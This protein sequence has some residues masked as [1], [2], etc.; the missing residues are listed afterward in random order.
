M[1]STANADSS[2]DGPLKTPRAQSRFPVQPRYGHSTSGSESASDLRSPI[3]AKT[4]LPTRSHTRVP[5]SQYNASQ[6]AAPR[7]PGLASLALGNERSRSNSESIIQSTQNNR[8]K[9]NG[10][11]GKKHS[12]LGVLDE[13]RSNRNSHHL[14]GQS[15]G[16]ALR[17]GIRVGDSSPSGSPSRGEYQRGMLVCRLASLPEHKPDFQPTDHLTEGAK[18]VL[19]SVDMIHPMA[20]TL[21]SVIK[22]GKTKR[23]SV[24][25]DFHSSIMHIGHLDQELLRLDSIS[26]ESGKSELQCRRAVAQATHDCV[27]AHQRVTALLLRVARHLVKDCD[28]RYVRTFMLTLYGS[29]NEL[30]NASKPLGVGAPRNRP[31]KNNIQRVSTICE[32]PGEGEHNYMSDRSMTPTQH[33]KPAGRLKSGSNAQQPISHTNL[34]PVSAQNAVPLYANGRS[35]SN[36]R[37]GPFHSSASSSV[38]ST[39][40]S[41]ESFSRASVVSRSR[42]GSINITTQQARAGKQETAQFEKI[43]SILSKSVEEGHGIISHLQSEFFQAL[44]AADKPYAN[45]TVRDRWA[46]LANN[47]MHCLELTE[48]LKASLS[49]VRLN[50]REAR[51]LRD[52]WRL[53]KN[54]LDAYG[55]LLIAIKQAIKDNLVDPSLRFRMRPVLTCIKEITSL[56]AASPWN[57]LTFDVDPQATP[58]ATPQVQTQLPALNGYQHRTRGSGGSSAG[59][60]S[61][62]PANVP[63]TPLSAALG[64]A[65]QATVHAPPPTPAGNMPP[66]PGTA[67]LERSFEGDIFQRADTYQSL[68]Q[69]M[70]PR[71]QV[72]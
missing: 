10:L 20:S 70:I 48:M 50:D 6:M 25:R 61:P 63:A 44:D 3:Y 40:R 41:G 16:S 5:S 18:G 24:E 38:V 28:R 58:Q 31:P 32:I 9:R 56:V 14:R 42:S 15:H 47:T 19:Y 53:T 2:D 55:D 26:N 11:I 59:G 13:T 64:P 36:S 46:I 45:T 37:A 66:T 29:M 7:R 71:R 72:L 65:A 22:D 33:R 27:V 1:Y 23:S 54:F 68:Q 8:T 12:D 39:P 34:A 51:N 67:S 4:V 35:R 60:T 52:F 30:I 49:N 69:T 43:F 21:T 62:Y 17:N 57:G